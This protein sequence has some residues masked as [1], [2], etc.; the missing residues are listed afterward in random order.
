MADTKDLQESIYQEMRSKIKEDDANAPLRNGPFFYY[1]KN[2]E[3]QQYTV[4][5]R[6]MAP[7]GEGPGHVDEVMETGSGAPAEEVLLEE[8]KEAKGF[9]FYH[10]GEVKVNIWATVIVL[11]STVYFFV[12]ISF[13]VGLFLPVKINVDYLLV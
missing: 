13:N 6:R 10:V 7:G 2:L 9:E 5:C 8:N 1:T 12:H 11:G 4:H 3:G